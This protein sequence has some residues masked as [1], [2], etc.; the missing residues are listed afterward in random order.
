V[1][2]GSDGQANGAQANT[3]SA[4]AEALPE[5]PSIYYAVVI[6]VGCP[7][8]KHEVQRQS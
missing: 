7:G 3:F 6:V 8:H 1:P 4:S 5:S 2:S